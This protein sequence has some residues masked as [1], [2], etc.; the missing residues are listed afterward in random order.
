MAIPC[1]KCG[2]NAKDCLCTP[3]KTKYLRNVP[4]RLGLTDDRM[5]TGK[6]DRGAGRTWTS[7]AERKAWMK[8][9]GMENS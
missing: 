9:R 2:V 1:S 6:K 4:V 7:Y 3:L 8:A 5:Y